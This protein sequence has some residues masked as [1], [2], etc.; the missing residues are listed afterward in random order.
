MR[1]IESQNTPVALT[2]PRPGM[3][4][5]APVS[6]SRGGGGGGGGWRPN[7]RGFTR[8]GGADG[9]R[10]GVLYHDGQFDDARLAVCLAASAWDHG[11]TPINYCQVTGLLR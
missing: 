5:K 1:R 4:Y 8:G 10:G 3:S 7:P 6:G 9:L 11:A 2:T